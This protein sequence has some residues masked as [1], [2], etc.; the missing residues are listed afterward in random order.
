M[1]S[2]N[3]ISKKWP[4]VLKVTLLLL[5]CCTVTAQEKQNERAIKATI[6]QN[7]ARLDDFSSKCERRTKKA[8][9][10]YYSAQINE[11]RKSLLNGDEKQIHSI[12]SF[13]NHIKYLPTERRPKNDDEM[14]INFILNRFL[15]QNP[16]IKVFSF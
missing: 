3:I 5:S 16:N 4:F 15:M 13:F 12:N 8:E 10:Y 1:K 2:Q 11:Y 7:N 6:E 9:R 14:D